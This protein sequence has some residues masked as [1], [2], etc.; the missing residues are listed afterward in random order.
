[1]IAVQSI[2]IKLWQHTSIL[3][4]RTYLDS[5]FKY[6]AIIEPSMI[7]NRKSVVDSNITGIQ[8]NENGVR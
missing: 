1:M 7:G 3:C 6:K 4:S 2:F 5:R 8:D